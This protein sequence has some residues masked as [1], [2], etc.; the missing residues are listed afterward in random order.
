MAKKLPTLIIDSRE[1]QP[2]D[3]SDD[4]DFEG[5]I[6]QKLDAGDYSLVGLESIIAIERKASCDELWMNLSSKRGRE[7]LKRE[8]ERF[9]KIKHRFII[10]EQ[11]YGEIVDPSSYYVNKAGRN[12]FSPYM[13][14]SVI[15]RELIDYMT[16]FDV[17]VIFAGTKARSLIKKILLQVYKN[18]DPDTEISS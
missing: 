11:D 2:L 10:V 12:K 4:P 3:I 17:H 8:M 1:R 9:K 13:P 7:R 16:S 6:T 5:S 18:H 14:V 15:M